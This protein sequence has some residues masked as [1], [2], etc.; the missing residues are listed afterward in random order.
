MPQSRLLV[1]SRHSSCRCGSSGSEVAVKSRSPAWE[2]EYT[3]DG[4]AMFAQRLIRSPAYMRLCFGEWVRVALRLADVD[5]LC[6][7]VSHIH[8]RRVSDVCWRTWPSMFGIVAASQSCMRVARSG[9]SWWW[10]SCRI[11][12]L[13]CAGTRCPVSAKG[14]RAGV[15]SSKTEANAECIVEEGHSSSC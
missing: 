1:N 12:R 14:L 4:R 7:W 9:W 15:Q 8:I 6:W 2:G 5:C 10:E 11:W 13:A 3:Q